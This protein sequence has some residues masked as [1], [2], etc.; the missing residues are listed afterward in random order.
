MVSEYH[1][2]GSAVLRCDPEFSSIRV[3][4][5]DVE[6]YFDPRL[7]AE[8]QDVILTECRAGRMFNMEYSYSGWTLSFELTD[9]KWG[10]YIDV[11]AEAVDTLAW[12]EANCAKP[13]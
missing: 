4:N 10:T 1:P 2:S 9:S 7:M 5:R 11:P 3:R 12:L 6:Y 13:E 8:L